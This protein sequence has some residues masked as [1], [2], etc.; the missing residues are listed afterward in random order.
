M[1]LDGVRK[2]TDANGESVRQDMSDKTRTDST[3]SLDC[4]PIL[5]SMSV[6]LVFL[7]STF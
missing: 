6:V 5:V 3:D 7:F 2:K 4:L 1:Q